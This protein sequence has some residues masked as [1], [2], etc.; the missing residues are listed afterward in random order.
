MLEVL[1]TLP[2]GVTRKCFVE[3]DLAALDV[4]AGTEE[5]QE[6]YEF[7]TASLES[8]IRECEVKVQNGT[9]RNLVKSDD[10]WPEHPDTFMFSLGGAF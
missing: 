8:T 9:V 10:Y 5:N 4:V 3:G 2:N 7:L 1:F 6:W